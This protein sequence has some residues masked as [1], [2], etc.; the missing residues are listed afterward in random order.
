MSV[1]DNKGDMKFNKAKIQQMD[2][3][4]QMLLQ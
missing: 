2:S 3:E 1:A 4:K